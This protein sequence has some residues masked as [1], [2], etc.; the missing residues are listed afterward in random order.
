M[1]QCLCLPDFCEMKKLIRISFSMSSPARS[2]DKM[3]TVFHSKKPFLAYVIS[4]L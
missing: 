3:L 1:P 2:L 4:D